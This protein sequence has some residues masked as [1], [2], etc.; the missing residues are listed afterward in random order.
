MHLVPVD[1]DRPSLQNTRMRTRY[2]SGLRMERFQVP[3]PWHNFFKLLCWN[4]E[5]G[6]LQ[7]F[8]STPL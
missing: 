8:S 4:K 7:E 5:T 1:P 3:I 6:A 2:L